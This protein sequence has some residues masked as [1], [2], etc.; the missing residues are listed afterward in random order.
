MKSWEVFLREQGASSVRWHDAY[1]AVLNNPKSALLA[2]DNQEFVDHLVGA[3]E[4][5]TTESFGSELD[6][7][8]PDGVRAHLIN[9]DSLAFLYDDGKILGFASSQLFAAEGIFYLHGVAIAPDFKGRGAGLALSK[10]LIENV[11]LPWLAFTTQNPIM[12]CFAESLCEEVYPRPSMKRTSSEVRSLAVALNVKRRWEG[13]D[14]RTFRIE[15]LYKSCLYGTIPGCAD[16]VVNEWFERSLGISDGRTRN[17]FLFVG[18]L[19][20]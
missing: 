15:N 14:L 7:D 11:G 10:A 1:L 5:I 6:K 9:V 16:P 12:F 8:G 2:D 3:L 4:K 18:K 19:K 20:K 13:L 17:A